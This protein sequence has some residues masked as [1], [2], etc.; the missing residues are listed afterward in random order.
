MDDH[1]R[2]KTFLSILFRMLPLKDTI[3]RFVREQVKSSNS[4]LFNPRTPTPFNPRTAEDELESGSG[5]ARGKGSEAPPIAGHPSV[6]TPLRQTQLAEKISRV[7]RE[8][9]RR[10]LG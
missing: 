10:G 6:F 7:L 8:T 4:I 2:S 5:H 9:N 1:F 3:R